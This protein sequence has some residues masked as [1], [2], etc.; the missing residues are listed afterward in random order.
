ML[1]WFRTHEH[2]SPSLPVWLYGVTA[3]SSNHLNRFTE[4]PLQRNE[5]CGRAGDV[6]VLPVVRRMSTMTYDDLGE[7]TASAIE[8]TGGRISWDTQQ[9]LR[10]RREENES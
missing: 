2:H 10:E 3:A 9:I 1:S 6:L 4:G 7:L 8:K 5:N